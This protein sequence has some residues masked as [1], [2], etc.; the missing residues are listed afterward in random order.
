MTTGKSPDYTPAEMQAVFLSRDIAN[1][2][3]GAAGASAAIPMAPATHAA[4]PPPGVG[5]FAARAVT[6]SAT[7]L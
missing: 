5:C 1:G 4:P 7:P 6:K 2:E 3:L